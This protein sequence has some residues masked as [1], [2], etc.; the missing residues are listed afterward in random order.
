MVS[1]ALKVLNQ[2]AQGR[3]G[4]S[5]TRKFGETLTADTSGITDPNGVP[6]G[7]FTYQWFTVDLGGNETDIDGAKE[8]SYT[9]PRDHGGLL[10][11]GAGRLRRQPRIR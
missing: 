3:P 6:E 5:G 7:A 9:I 2:P 1:L 4:I 10:P 11:G 8:D